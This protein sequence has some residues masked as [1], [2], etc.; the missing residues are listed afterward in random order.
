M[1]GNLLSSRHFVT[2][3]RKMFVG[4]ILPHYHGNKM[5]LTLKQKFKKMC[6]RDR[7]CPVDFTLTGINSQVNKATFTVDLSL[8]SRDARQRPIHV[9]LSLIHI[10]MCIRDS[11]CTMII[12]YN[13]NKL[14]SSRVFI[15][16]YIAKTKLAAFG[17]ST[18]QPL[19]VN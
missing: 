1:Q 16:A 19:L 15:I 6:I 14:K 4:N 12:V 17:R 9:Q 5:T 3:I 2:H 18:T 8:Q 11:R 13:K 10:Q 7:Q